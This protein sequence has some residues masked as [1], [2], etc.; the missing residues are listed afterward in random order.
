MNQ[1]QITIRSP[2]VLCHYAV[3]SQLEVKKHCKQC[4]RLIHNLP[5][6][7]QATQ[8]HLEKKPMRMYRYTL[9]FLFAVQRKKGKKIKKKLMV[10]AGGGGEEESYNEEQTLL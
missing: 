5:P 8:P 6:D 4:H 2:L 10:G 1:Q 9:N 3:L 7:R